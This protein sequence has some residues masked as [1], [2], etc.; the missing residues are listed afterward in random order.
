MRQLTI[1]KHVARCVV[2]G[3]P[4]GSLLHD[5]LVGIAWL[6][7]LQDDKGVAYASGQ[8]KP[9]PSWMKDLDYIWQCIVVPANT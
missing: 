1:R 7:I 2:E 6:E 3:L 8:A 9:G 5:G 4:A